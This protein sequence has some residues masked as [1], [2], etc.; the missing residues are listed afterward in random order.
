MNEQ[1]PT[2]LDTA[3]HMNAVEH[4][5]SEFMRTAPEEQKQHFRETL[6]LLMQC[7]GVRP[8]MAILANVVDKSSGLLMVHGINM[9]PDEMHLTATLSLQV[10]EERN[11]QPPVG[12]EVH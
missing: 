1:H 3:M 8:K 2:S 12:Q 10:L 9:S 6:N 7:Y 4:E 5:F 11:Q